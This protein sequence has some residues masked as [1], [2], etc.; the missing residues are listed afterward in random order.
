MKVSFVM[1][2]PRHSS[3]GIFSIAPLGIIYLG[4]ILK[5]R[6]YD[7]TIYDEARNHI[8]NEK[9]GQIAPELLKSDFIGLSVISPAANRGLRML[10]AIARQNPKIRT[11]VG[12]PH[13][14][15]R[16]QAEEFARYADVVVQK[17]GEDIIEE[18]VGGKLCGIV[19]GP[20]VEDLNRLPIPDFSLMADKKKRLTDF[21]K[22]TPITTAR[23]CPRNCEFCTVSNIH[24]KKVRRRSTELVLQELKQRATEGYRRIFFA[25]DNFSVQPSKRLPLL[26]ALI[27]EQ[28]AGFWFASIIVQDEVPGILRGGKEYVEK[29]KKAGIKT[30]MLGVESFDDEK[31]QALH[32]THNKTDSEKA[33][34]LLRQQGIIIYAF[35][36]A[37]PEIDDKAS[38]QRQFR[39][40]REEGITY[41]DMTIETPFPG[42]PYWERY[43]DKLTATK[44]GS[45]DWDQWTLLC[46]VIPTRHM[47][48]KAF[49]KAVKKNML[50]FYS[51]LRALKRMLKGKIRS[52]LTILYVWFTTGRMYS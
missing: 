30:V 49:Q 11:G 31:L 20:R 19:S 36:M 28:K 17:E 43:K 6:G 23:G 46:P 32:K 44:N 25:D 39:K 48:Q 27:R 18:V 22:L 9:K 51:P 52:G 41:A 7:V 40:L 4:T 50:W 8:F 12:G 34:R 24:G 37:K 13:I 33:I 45:P 26:E 29:M 15:G 14:L 3:Y 21:F 16:E 5:E 42:T 38:I 47:S 1:I 10:K 2:R 35:G